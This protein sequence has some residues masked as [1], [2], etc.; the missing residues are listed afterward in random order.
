MRNRVECL[1]EF[2]WSKILSRSNPQPCLCVS[3]SLQSR[4]SNALNLNVNVLGKSLDS[5]AAASRLVGEPLL[6]LGVHVLQIL[7]I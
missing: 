2:I 6:I 7:A 3:Y 5:N 1:H 4:Q